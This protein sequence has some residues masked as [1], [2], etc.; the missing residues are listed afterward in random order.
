MR[1]SGVSRRRLLST[2]ATVGAVTLVGCGDAASQT[3]TPTAPGR[4]VGGY[5]APFPETA[6]ADDGGASSGGKPRAKSRNRQQQG[7]GYIP[8]GESNE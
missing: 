1:T 7:Y 2:T 3:G 8:Y 6:A 4:A 5:G